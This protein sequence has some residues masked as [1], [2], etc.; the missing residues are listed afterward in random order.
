[1]LAT[2]ICLFMKKKKKKKLLHLVTTLVLIFGAW[3]SSVAVTANGRVMVKEMLIGFGCAVFYALLVYGLLAFARE[4][5][6]PAQARRDYQTLQ[7]ELFEL[8]CLD[9][10]TLRFRLEQRKTI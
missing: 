6:T 4:V 3:G 8:G 5:K 1:V 7:L 2:A 10:A 9:E